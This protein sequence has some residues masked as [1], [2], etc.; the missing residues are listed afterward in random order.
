MADELR[1]VQ[2]PPEVNVVVQYHHARDESMYQMPCRAARGKLLRS[3]RSAWV[4]G[5]CLQE[6]QHDKG[7]RRTEW[8]A[9]PKRP[10]PQEVARREPREGAWVQ[11]GPPRQI[12]RRGV[13]ALRASMRLLW[14]GHRRVPRARPCQRAFGR[15]AT[16]WQALW[17][18]AVHLR[19][20][21]RVP[22]RLPSPLPQLQHGQGLLWPVPS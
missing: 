12:P 13:G 3:T 22:G 7:A 19:D 17:Y 14:G 16:G 15:G 1:Q 20:Q 11:Q 8:Q 4:I 21:K 9:G 18:C 10:S 2:H 6:V 5:C